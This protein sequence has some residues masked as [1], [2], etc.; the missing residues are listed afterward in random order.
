MSIMNIHIYE[1]ITIMYILKKGN[2]V[3]HVATY[4]LYSNK[5]IFIIANS[6]V[7]TQK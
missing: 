5:K 7:D 4:K 3:F 2:I 6:F 1:Y